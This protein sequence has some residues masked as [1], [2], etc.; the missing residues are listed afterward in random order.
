MRHRL[1]LSALAVVNATVLLAGGAALAAVA[2]APAQVTIAPAAAAAPSPVPVV[3]PTAVPPR[4]VARPVVKRTVTRHVAPPKRVVRHVTRVV[5]APKPALTPQQLMER[6]IAKIPGYR[7]G[8]A[9]W[10]MTTRYGHW[11]IAEL[12]G[13]NIYI[14]PTVPANRMY[15]VVAHEWSHILSMRAYGNDVNTALA[16]LNK[17]FGGSGISGAET[18]ADCMARVLGATW[19]HYTPC[20]SVAWRTAARTL[21]AGATL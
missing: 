5:A 17:F 1:A 14:S 13:T 12:G 16:A 8:I 21:L 7:S 11:G 19:T 6:A 15:D 3:A 4:P 20:S 18:A 9:T 10:T 2:A